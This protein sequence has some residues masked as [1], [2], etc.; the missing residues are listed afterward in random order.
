MDEVSAREKKALREFCLTSLE[1]KRLAEEAKAQKKEDTLVVKTA[2]T[3]LDEWIR[4]QGSK[5]FSIP[6]QRYKELEA[7]LSAKGIPPMPCYVRLKKQTSDSTI[8]PATVEESIQ[9]VCW[10]AVEAAEGSPL[11]RIAKAIV[12][13]LRKNIRTTRESI[14]LSESLEKGTKHLEVPDLDE[15]AIQHVLKLHTAQYHAKQITQATKG[16]E[17][18]SKTELKKLEG[19]VDKVLTKTNRTAQPITLEGVEG[20]H[21]IVKKTSARSEKLTLGTFQE[22]VVEAL[23]QLELG[24]SSP[25]A[26]WAALEKQ[27]S[28]LIKLLLLKINSI[29]K[30]ESTNIKLVSKMA[31]E[32]DD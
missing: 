24:D 18:E 21:K 6:K 17:Q 31:M 4:K 20:T 1:Q 28:T 11:E 14:Q 10:E 22:I 29:P 32:A 7:E 25:Q 8:S 12:D 13:T 19:V 15:E 9:E 30:K 23:E 26:T 3:E 5:C 2:R 16:A 27:K